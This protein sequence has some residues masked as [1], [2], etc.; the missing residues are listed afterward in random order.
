MV[1]SISKMTILRLICHVFFYKGSPK[2]VQVFKGQMVRYWLLFS[3]IP[4]SDT[5]L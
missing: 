2:D 1:Q 3:N 5:D 4:S